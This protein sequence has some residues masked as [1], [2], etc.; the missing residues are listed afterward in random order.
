[1]FPADINPGEWLGSIGVAFLLLAFFLNL[2]GKLGA[3]T[4]IY[5]AMNAGGAGLACYASYLIGF[6]PFVILEGTW[7][8]VALLA[9]AGSL[10]RGTPAAVKPGP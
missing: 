8:A 4:L 1:M 7:C 3:D 5:Q 9:V 10:G 6:L 2:W